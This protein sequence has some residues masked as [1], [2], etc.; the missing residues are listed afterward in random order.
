MGTSTQ[1][2]LDFSLS[3]VLKR[4]ISLVL[5]MLVLV[6]AAIYLTEDIEEFSGDSLQQDYVQLQ[7]NLDS[8]QGQWLIKNKPKRLSL[9]W[10]D[11]EETLAMMDAGKALTPKLRQEHTSLWVSASGFPRLRQQSVAACEQMWRSLLP[12]SRHLARLQVIVSGRTCEYQ[13]KDNS[14]V[15]LD[16]NKETASFIEV[17]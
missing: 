8:I 11:A 4:A 17:K 10:Q 15:I 3:Q 14:R 12:K 1:G 7:H 5:I 13:A 2:W 6:F 16:F 9:T